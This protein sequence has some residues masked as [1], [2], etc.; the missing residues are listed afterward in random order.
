VYAH[1]EEM[2]GIDG[3]MD[4]LVIY[5]LATEKIDAFPAKSK[6]A[7]ETHTALQNFRGTTYVDVVYSDNSREIKQAVRW[8]G[9]AHRTSIPGIPANNAIAESRVKIVVYGTRTALVNAGLPAAFWPYAARHFCLGLTIRDRGGASAYEKQLG[10]PFPGMRIPFECKVFFKP[11]P[12]SK[13]QPRKFE[14]QA[15]PGLFFGH[16]LDPRGQVVR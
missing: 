12:L 2:E 11:S 3:S 5:D 9:F 15:V 16:K 14:G 1:S 10:E 8:L 4:M 13:S 7:D 6:N